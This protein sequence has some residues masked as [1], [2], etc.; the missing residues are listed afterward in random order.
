M[1]QPASERLSIIPNQF[2]EPFQT[3]VI[4][5]LGMSA[6]EHLPRVLK[7]FFVLV[8]EFPPPKPRYGVGN[9]HPQRKKF[10]PPEKA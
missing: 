4:G 7:G 9:F 5:V 6:S 1:K 10:P 2:F 8:G 3:S